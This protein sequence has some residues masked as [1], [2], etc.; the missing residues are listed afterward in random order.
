MV[1]E[2]LTDSEGKVYLTW[3]L[4]DNEFDFQM[5]NISVKVDGVYI[6]GSQME[7][8]AILVPNIYN[9]NLTYGSMTDQEGNNYKTIVIGTQEWMADNIR[10]GIFRNGDIIP[11]GLSA[12]EWSSTIYSEQGACAYYNDNTSYAY[13]YGKLYNWFACVDARQL[14][15]LGWH[16]PNTEDWE[17]LT[18]YLN[19]LGINGVSPGGIIKSIAL[20][21][22][23]NTGATNES[24]FSGLPGGYRSNNGGFYLGNQHGTWYSSTECPEYF[25][26]SQGY[27]VH[28]DNSLYT[29]AVANPKSVGFSVRC[30]RD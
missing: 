10:T 9:P 12:S 14:C 4:G 24:G 1:N 25:N 23:P 11:T 28:Y 27:G 21:D 30:L 17:V 19:P 6:Q 7:V 5:L 18:N 3:T 16:V 20:W 13:P 15:P 2:N 22:L 8:Y 26:S 29:H